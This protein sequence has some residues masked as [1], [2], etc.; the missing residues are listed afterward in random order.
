VAE[1]TYDFP[2]FRPPSEADSLLLR[3]TRGC[4]WNRCAFCPMYKGIQFEKRSVKAVKRDIDTAKVYAGSGVETVF[5]GDSDSLVINTD[6]LC[7]ILGHLH[8]AFPSLTRVTSYARGHTL[9]RK[10]LQG[11]TK[12][13]DSGLTRLHIGLETGHPRLLVQIKK[14][15][16]PETMI[17]GCTKAKD[18]GFEVSLYVLLGIGGEAQWQAHASETAKVLNRIDPD[19]IRVRTLA[20]Q[21]GT[22]VYQWWK[23]GSFEM[24]GPETILRE[25]KA[26]IKGLAVTSQYLSDHISNYAPINGRLPVDK[27]AMLSTIDEALEKLSKDHVFRAGLERMRR[28]RRL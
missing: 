13:R 4:P 24:P 17:R 11:L 8:G 9:K 23:E 27:T 5:I 14:G 7:E 18:A 15:A 20:P 1:D 26:L 3:V 21:P 12:L 6:E 10:S 28:L 19:F 16:S 25:Q 2:P 22:L